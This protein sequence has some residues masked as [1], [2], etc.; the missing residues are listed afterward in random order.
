MTCTMIPDLI[1]AEAVFLPCSTG[2][3]EALAIK[4]PQ[5]VRKV[6]SK[7]RHLRN[8]GFVGLKNGGQSP[9]SNMFNMIKSFNWH[10]NSSCVLTCLNKSQDLLGYVQI[11]P[12][13]SHPTSQLETVGV[14]HL[15]THSPVRT[16]WMRTSVRLMMVNSQELIA[17]ENIQK[18]VNN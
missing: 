6:T 3:G 7:G 16:R 13:P 14:R 18:Q 10:V 5:E 12:T 17:G 1:S 11:E 2:T 4:A 15:C 8:L 9:L